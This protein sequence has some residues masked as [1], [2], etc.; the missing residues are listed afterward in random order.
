MNLLPPAPFVLHFKSFSK[1]R[2][3]YP[4]DF[5]DA[6]A[7]IAECCNIGRRM[8][9]DSW[10]QWEQ[11]IDAAEEEFILPLFGPGVT[12]PVHL[13]PLREKRPGLTEM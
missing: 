12:A 10:F 9:K 3:L 4:L 8:N 13:E 7:D 1:R 11:M 5:V 2:W 6:V